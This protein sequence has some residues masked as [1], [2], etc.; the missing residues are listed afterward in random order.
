MVLMA[1]LMAL[2]PPM[3]V[4]PEQGVR[5][6]CVHDGDT[7]II[8][9][10]RIRLMDIDTPEMEAQCASESRLAVRARDRLVAILNSEQFVV[11]R[12][13]QERYGRTLAVVANS[14][15]SVGDQLVSEGLARTWS[16]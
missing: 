14:R 7:F 9:R 4:C 3:A 2:A 16:G 13:G 8:D 15:G 11:H 10:E 5:I 12:D 6:T 1:A